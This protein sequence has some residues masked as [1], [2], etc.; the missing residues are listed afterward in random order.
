MLFSYYNSVKSYTPTNYLIW[1]LPEV[2]NSDFVANQYKEFKEGRIKKNELPIITPSCTITS[3]KKEL[4]NVNNHSGLIWLD[5][6]TEKNPDVNINRVINEINNDCYTYL[7][8]HSPRGGARIVV[9]TACS[10]ICQHYDY[11]QEI[12]NYYQTKYNIVLDKSCSNVNRYCFLNPDEHIFINSNSITYRLKK[13]ST[14]VY[15][16]ITKSSITEHNNNFTSTQ[17]LTDINYSIDNQNNIDS[18]IVNSTVNTTKSGNNEKGINSCI[19]NIN[20]I[21]TVDTFFNFQTRIDENIF[22]D[23]QQPVY[24][25]G[26]KDCI[27]LYIGKDYCIKEGARQHTI[28]Y[29]SIVLLYNNPNI[30]LSA[31]IKTVQRLNRKYCEK[32]LKIKEITSICTSNYNKHIEGKLN[33]SKYTKKKYVFYSREFKGILLTDE[34]LTTV[35]NTNYVLDDIKKAAVKELVKKEKH[36]LSMKCYRDGKQSEFERKIYDAI[37]TCQLE[38]KEGKKITYKQL[39]AVSGIPVPT[40]KKR[41][42]IELKSIL[43]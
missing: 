20:M 29:I 6:D 16:G 30:E 31:L 27:D 17:T 10:D 25:E 19:Y 12:F 8:W 42:T 1:E 43:K 9:Y 5:L 2:I 37:E 40:I 28:G 24:I 39:S 32:P 11:W 7:T 21:C 33:Y 22:T 36:K 41:I 3:G 34:Q 26:G 14:A 35:N 4:D 15:S 23:K 38:Q 18:N 13:V